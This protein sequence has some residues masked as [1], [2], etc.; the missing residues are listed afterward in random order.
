M[1]IKPNILGL[2]VNTQ[3]ASVQFIHNK[4]GVCVADAGGQAAQQPRLLTFANQVRSSKQP[5]QSSR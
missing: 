2:R 3:D 4:F 5:R 1:A